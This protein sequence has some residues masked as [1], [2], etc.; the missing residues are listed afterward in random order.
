MKTEPITLRFSDFS[1]FT[2]DFG[3]KNTVLKKLKVS[4]YFESA[5]KMDPKLGKTAL[6]VMRLLRC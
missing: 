1:L 3:A 6:I 4:H 2:S 5:V